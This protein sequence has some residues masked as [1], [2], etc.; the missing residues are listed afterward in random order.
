MA[1]PLHCNYFSSE[2]LFNGTY[3]LLALLV[4]KQVLAKAEDSHKVLE[5]Y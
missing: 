4:G 5:L 3:Q 1:K 2:S